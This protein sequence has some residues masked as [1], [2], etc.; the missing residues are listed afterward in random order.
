[1][2]CLHRVLDSLFALTVF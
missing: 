2:I 1:M